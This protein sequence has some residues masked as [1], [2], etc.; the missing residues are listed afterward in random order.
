MTEH[1][2]ILEIGR[3]VGG[4]RQHEHNRS[5]ARETY[6]REVL[7]SQSNQKA[8]RNQ[9]TG[10]EP[11]QAI[12][13]AG[14]R[15]NKPTP[16]LCAIQLVT[17]LA[18]KNI[19]T[20]QDAIATWLS[21][22]FDVVAVNAL[23]EQEILASAFGG[24]KF[25]EPTLTLE[26]MYGKPYVSIRDLIGA[27]AENPGI[28][29]IINSDIRFL[30][31]KSF[32]TILADSID[33]SM[34]TAGSLFLFSRLELGQYSS[35]V[36]ARLAERG[37]QPVVDGDV[38]C[39]GFDLMVACQATWQKILAAMN[40]EVCLGM[41]VPWWDYFIPLLS[42]I[43]GIP[44]YI[45]NPTPIGHP[46]HEAVY[47]KEIWIKS[48]KSLL[49]LIHR[50]NHSLTT[51]NSDKLF[52]EV[53]YLESLARQVAK[54]IHANSG[55]VNFGQYIVPGPLEKACE[56]SLDHLH[57]SFLTPETFSRARFGN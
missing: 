29:G 26:R 45:A 28:S 33:S 18:P 22:G 19:I 52:T 13:S 3:L 6:A 21:N 40:E 1:T 46:Y 44:T 36:S 39:Y 54:T 49:E 27:C 30:M 31:R 43:N 4:F 17:S 55:E 37:L 14:Q 41:G 11:A 51:E 47:S 15:S 24:I 9:R 20:Q 50:N 32:E 38:Y 42:L 57:L 7:Q 34:A 10:R 53:G 12:K 56:S 23:V 25:R 35:Q 5:H 2:E 16:N 48:A 8:S